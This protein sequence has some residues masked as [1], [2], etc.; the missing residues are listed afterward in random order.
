[1]S[2][3]LEKIYYDSKS[4]SSAFT[5]P[6]NVYLEA[7]RQN[8]AITLKEVSDYLA[9]QEVY[10]I[11]RPKRQRFLRNRVV[12]TSIDSDWQ[13]DLCDMQ[14]LKGKNRGYNYILTVIDVLSKF[15]WAEPLKM[16]K[17]ENVVMAFRKILKESDRRPARL[18][19]D[20]GLEFLGRPFR[21]FLE[22]EGIQQLYS[23]N[24]T[25]KAS[26][27]E[28]YN[29]TLKTR[30]WKYFSYAQ[31]KKYLTILPH[32][33]SA[34]NHSYHRSIKMRPVDVNRTNETVV[35]NTLYGGDR[36]RPKLKFRYN[37][38][39]S[40]RVPVKKDKGPFAKG[41]EA[42]FTKQIY[43]ID[44]RLARYPPVYRVKNNSTGKLD[45]RVYYDNEIVPA[46]HGA[47]KTK[48][49]IVVEEEED[50]SEDDEKEELLPKRTR[51]STQR[52]GWSPVR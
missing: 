13:A 6:H 34:I 20:R 48:P 29:R 23:H 24:D 31:N 41:Y 17:P 16:K 44:Q 18:F 45:P 50:G 2:Q 10:S 9:T 33:V 32:I 4:S 3:L 51:K 38:G 35:W 11:H 26:V 21:H 49:T 36:K 15:A 1:M 12:A 5:T 43:T 40:V 47:R 39:D 8:P 30:L 7:K 27:A 37:I 52:Y 25:V 19:T 46:V 42:N 14:P 22:E 28:R